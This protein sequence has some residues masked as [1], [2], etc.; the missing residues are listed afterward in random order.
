MAGTAESLDG[1]TLLFA[2]GTLM[3]DRS[4][5]EVGGRWAADAVRGRLHDLGPYPALVGLGDPG[6]GWVEGYVRPVDAA[7]LRDVLDSYEGVAEGLFARVVTTTRA[8]RLAWIYVYGRAVP[9]GARG[10]L[11]RWDGPRGMTGPRAAREEFDD[12]LSNRPESVDG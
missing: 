1:P 5:V 11:P 3:P 8:G 2:Y 4:R 12:G 10:P 6:A 9:P 7:E